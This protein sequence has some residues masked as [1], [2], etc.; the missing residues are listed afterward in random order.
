MDK[1]E[2]KL[3]IIFNSNGPFT[4]SGYGQQMAELM[5]LIRDEDYPLAIIDY[6]GL[7]GGKLMLDGILH[8]PKINHVFGSDALVL[9]AQDFKADVVFTLQDVWVLHPQ[10]LA[11]VNR[12]ISIVP[13]DHNPVPNAVLEKLKYAYRIVT[14]SKFGQK[15]LQR[16]GLM[17]TYIPHTVNT[18]IFKPMDKKERKKV[19]GI[20]ENAFLCGM[21]AANK[22]NPPRKCFQEVMDAF[23]MFL[24][25]VPEALLYIHTNPENPGGFPIKEYG[26][27]IGIEGK[28]LFPDNYQM[29]FNTGKEQ[30][31]LIY[32]TMDVLLS[33]SFSEGFCIPNIE[34]QSC[35]IPVI[36][37]DWTSMSELV[38][39]G[40]TGYRTKVA[41]KRFTALGSYAGIPDTQD[42]F[43]GL[44]AV[45]AMDKEQT[46]QACRDFIVENYDTTKVF[47]ECWIPFLNHLEKE[48]YKESS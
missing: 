6:F 7:E 40:V 39:P 31:A 30:M 8:Y 15:E 4:Q 12:F 47:K 29:S 5:P 3:R 45:Y 19:A 18:E 48:I 23:K 28:L 16:K 26:K 35:G 9:H 13:I 38:I 22:D 37:N 25:K 2:K 11:K 17:S 33:P 20:P 24:E 43:N 36:T 27:F 44:M 41:S 34:A 10:D 14:Y 21:V 46:K 42:I 32:N 1:K